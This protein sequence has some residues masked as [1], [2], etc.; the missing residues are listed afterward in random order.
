MVSPLGAAE[1]R[2]LAVRLLLDAD[3]TA[4]L[5]R[6]FFYDLEG[7][8]PTWFASIVLFPCAERAVV[9]AVPLVVVFAI[10]YL[11]FLMAQ[12][13]WTRVAFIV[14]GLV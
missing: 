9:I 6:Y 8:I 10:F 7:N 13:P 11:R 1:G 3:Q 5:E 2:A 12:P 4:S 14:S